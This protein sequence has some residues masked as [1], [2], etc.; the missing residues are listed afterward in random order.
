MAVQPVEWVLVVYYGPSAHRAT[1]GRLSNTKY[2]KDYIQLSKKEDFL[3]ALVRLFPVNVGDDGSVPLTYRWPAGTTPGALVFNSAD[4]PHLKWETS[5]G[6]P[7]AWKMSLSPRE[8][9]AETIPGNPAHTEF[10]AAE[11]ELELLASRGA[12][13]PYLMAIKLHDE[14]TTLH[15][16]AYLSGPSAEYAWANLN[17]A[18]LPIQGLAAKT[19]QSSALAWETFASGGSVPSTAVRHA[20]SRLESSDASIAVLDEFDADTARGLAA[21]LRHPG[22]GV[23][24]DPS[25]NHDAWILP[26][27][28]SEGLATSVSVFLE[29]LNAR[30]PALTQGDAA[31]EA[32]E[33]D[34]S[35]VEVFQE[36]I[37]DQD[38]CVADSVVTTKTRG[39]AQRVFA[40]AVKSNYGYRCAITGIESKDFLVASHI[41]P[42]SED[43]SIRLDPSNGVCLSLLMDRAFELGHLLI[44]DDLT[45][46]IDWTRVGNDTVLRQQLEPHDGQ[47]LTPPTVGAPRAEYL[48]RRRTLVARTS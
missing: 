40:N 30:Y 43:Q 18:P 4:R 21:Y 1:Y 20:L 11:N 37:K 44:E 7:N 45:V 8:D 13:Q 31:A 48:Q 14:P 47:K 42:W 17:I 41:V 19:S 24:F 12:G 32:A 28:M 23:F 46:R 10:E 27:P 9:T 25:R 26:A 5:L 2:T 29:T 34:P 35:E 6:A 16:R 3:D 39:S 22:Y 15:L 38:Y 33:P 36:Q